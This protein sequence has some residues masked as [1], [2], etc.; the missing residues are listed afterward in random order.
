MEIRVEEI[1]EVYNT[2][3]YVKKIINEELILFF[4]SIN[5]KLISTTFNNKILINDTLKYSTYVNYDISDDFINRFT[6]DVDVPLEIL[7]KDDRDTEI[8]KV[9]N[10]ALE[11]LYIL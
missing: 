4:E 6:L 10:K 2:L 1:K 8:R 3:E 11:N 7:C 9:V 5:Y